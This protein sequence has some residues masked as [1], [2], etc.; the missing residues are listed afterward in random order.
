[1]RHKE[2]MPPHMMSASSQEEHEYMPPHM[3]SASS[4]EKHEYMP[5]HLLFVLY[6]TVLHC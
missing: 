3:M 5:P 6:C 4:Q 1:M 2:Y